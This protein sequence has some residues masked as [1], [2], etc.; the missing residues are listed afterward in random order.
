ML[1]FGKQIGYHAIV[2]IEE[3]IMLPSNYREY[4][5]FI[6]QYGKKELRKRMQERTAEAP[7]DILIYK[8]EKTALLG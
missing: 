3:T 4:R 1:F 6:K 8:K 2:L 7:S 5:N